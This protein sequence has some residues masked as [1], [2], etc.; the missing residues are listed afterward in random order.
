MKITAQAVDRIIRA[1]SEKELS[2]TQLAEAVGVH[3]SYINKIL[4]GLL[5]SIP[6]D[7]ADKISDRLGIALRP[8]VF[9]QGTVSDTALKLSSHADTDP[10]FAAILETL[11]ALKEGEARRAVI[12]SVDTKYL[13]KLGSE[14]VR[15]VHAWEEPSGSYSP[16]VAVEVLK[17]LREFYRA[18]K[19]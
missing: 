19:F 17:F 5:P 3:R 14:I 18:G 6:D 4:R 15:I 2:Q 16:K 13:G 10:A 12:P 1:M 7:L 11:V 9:A 8:I